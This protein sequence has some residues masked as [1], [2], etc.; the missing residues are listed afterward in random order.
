[1]WRPQPVPTSAL[2]PRGGCGGSY[3][4]GSSARISRSSIRAV[5]SGSCGPWSIRWY[6]SRSTRSCSRSCCERESRKFGFFL[7]SALLP[8]SFLSGSVTFATDAVVG[9]AGLVRKVPFPLSVLP[10]TAVGFNLTH[11]GLQL[12][13]LLCHDAVTGS[14]SFLGVQVLLAIPAIAVAIS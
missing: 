4:S 1:M 7:L 9:N 11:F 8:W 5:R 2:A 14:T 6:S 13:V 10:M 3:S 12:L